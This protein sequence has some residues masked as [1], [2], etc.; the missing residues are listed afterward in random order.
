[1]ASPTKK[2]VRA[3][4]KRHLGFNALRP[5]QE[6]MIF[7]TLAIIPS[8]SGKSAIYQISGGMLGGPTLVVSPLIALQ[9]AQVETLRHIVDEFAVKGAHDALTGEGAA[10][11]DPPTPP[12]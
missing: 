6:E 12:G 9:R 5:G 10:G 1:M 7:A 8:G 4:A 2:T 11:T 3:Y